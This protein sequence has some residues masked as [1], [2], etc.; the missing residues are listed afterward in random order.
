MASIRTASGREIYYD[1]A[2][3]GPPLLLLCGYMSSRTMWARQVAAFAPRFRVITMDNRD[4]GESQPETEP[5]TIGD[6]ATDAVALLDA[7]AIDRAHVL[8][9][10]MGG[11][12][13]LHLA[14]DH[15]ERVDRLVLVSTNA[16]AGP[17][18]GFPVVLPTPDEWIAD[19]VER[20]RL[21]YT[22]MAAPGAFEAH[23]E[24][25]EEVARAASGNR[26]TFDGIVRQ[27]S[28]L[29]TTHDVRERLAGIVAP[30]LVIHGDVDRTVSKRF[31]RALAEGIPGARF[32]LMPG[33][34]HLPQLERPEAFEQLV[35]DFL[36]T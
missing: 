33:V 12:T 29:Q 36:A 6:L 3:E 30:T 23:P 26:L 21:R 24:R 7:L 19:P 10:S 2:G 35:L 11:F 8:G 32:E 9:H 15:L 4:A 1:L 25:L 22:Q 28:A 18:L 17:A 14:V 31:G 13:A 34:G 27:S 16:A 20:V 5:Y